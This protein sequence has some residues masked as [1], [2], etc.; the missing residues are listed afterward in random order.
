M[1]LPG[2]CRWLATIE[3]CHESG[4]GFEATTPKRI[5]KNKRD[6]IALA[7]RGT[8]YRE[9]EMFDVA[10]RDLNASLSLNNRNPMTWLLRG[11]VRKARADK[12]RQS[13]LAAKSRTEYSSAAKDFKVS[14]DLFNDLMKR[15]ENAPT[16]PGLANAHFNIG[17]VFYA[18]D[19]F[20]QALKAYD[21]AIE[22]DDNKALW[23]VSRGSAKLGL[24]DRVGAKQDYLK[25]IELRDELADAYIGLSNLYL[26]EE[27]FQKAFKYADLAV[28]EQSNNAMAL[29]SRGWILFK[30]GKVEEAIYDLNRAIR[31]APRLSIAYGNRGICYVAVNEFKKAIADHSSHLSLS[32]GNPFAFSNRAVAYLGRENMKRH[33]RTTKLPSKLHRISTKPLTD[34]PGSSRLA[35]KKISR[36]KNWQSKRPPQPAKFQSTKT[37]INWI[38]WLQ[39][40]PNQVISKK[41]SSL[42]NRP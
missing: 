23:F 15:V 31:F 27:D 14:I 38:P 7:I 33:F 39:R 4:D 11:V 42:P 26:I 6:E 41:P 29:N 13:G 35:Q 9:L 21:N 37:G 8:I 20:K 19:D 25:A 40:T 22:L 32:P 24:D 5:E 17:L 10:D 18:L 28:E 34:M 1:V 2:Q 12:F 36:W 3:K 30:L 16:P